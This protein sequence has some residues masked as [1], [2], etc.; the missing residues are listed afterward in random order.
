[1]KNQEP[2]TLALKQKPQGKGLLI[3][4]LVKETIVKESAG[5]G[6]SRTNNS[7]NP[8]LSTACSRLMIRLLRK[9][10]LGE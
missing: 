9:A 2:H 10:A 8:D 3:N 1:M 5:N 7:T 4:I 6:R